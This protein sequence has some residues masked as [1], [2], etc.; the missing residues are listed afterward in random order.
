M[1]KQTKCNVSLERVRYLFS[2]DP[3]TGLLTRAVDTW[4]GKKGT[5]IKNTSLNIDGE[6]HKTTRW[7]WFHYYGEW[8]S[9]LIDH[10]NRNTADNSIANLRIVTATQNQYNKVQA[11]PHGYKGITWRDRKKKPWIA[12]IRV[13]GTRINLGSFA[14]KEQAAKAYEEAALKYHGEY[15]QLG[16]R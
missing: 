15:A 3:F 10:I 16:V 12:K 7:I 5:V 6:Y 13:A 14:T 4:R 1:A 9:D 11:N 2:Y 8:P